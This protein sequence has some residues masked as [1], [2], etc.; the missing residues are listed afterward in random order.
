M[1]FWNSRYVMLV[2]RELWEHRTLWLA[3]AVVAALM[4]ILPMF[5]NFRAGP[6]FQINV[7]APEVPTAVQQ[8]FGQIVMVSLATVLGV[9]SC[10]V[11]VIY[12]LDSLFAERKDRSILFWK[13]L[14]VTDTE[15]VLSKLVL[16]LVIIPLMTLLLAFA[17]YCMLAG[18]LYL[19]YEQLRPA[20]ENLSLAQGL[21]SVGQLVNTWLFVLLWYAPVAAYLML[22]SVLARRAPLVY[23]VLPPFVVVMIESMLFGT[24]HVAR[25]LRRWLLPTSQRDPAS[26]FRLS[27]G[28]IMDG[29]DW[30]NALSQPDIWLGLAAA[31]VMVYIVIRLRRYRDD[32]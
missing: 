25:L 24:D 1:N 31:V 19:R 4:V 2:R 30:A 10:I 18:L 12:L 3:P 27:D 26:D 15:T 28:R 23:A 7:N 16:A 14:P 5:G 17:A 9:V 32:T 6:G 20:L 21:I 13:S 22:A 29:P 8:Y 11:S